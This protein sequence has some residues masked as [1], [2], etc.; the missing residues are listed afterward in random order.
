[1]AIQL[2]RASGRASELF[3]AYF[4]RFPKA[5][6]RALNRAGV[7]TRAVMAS[8]VAADT[9]LRVGTVKDEIRID[10][11]TET[12][13]IV[14]LEIR[15]R[16]I[17]L[18]EF[19]AT[20]PTPSRGRGRGVTAK[21]PGGAGRYPH[22]FIAT[23]RSGH[24]GVYQRTPDARRHGPAPNRSQLPI[25]EL[26]GPSLPHVFAKHATE[27]LTRGQESLLKNLQ[28]ELQFALSK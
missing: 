27:G 26:R 25:Y 18:I 16:R 19:K 10:K 1:M 6:V 13:P 15:G 5:I 2:D 7:S 3:D 8:R 28:S 23:M 9:N 24:T 22:A 21:L 20:G 4:D 14:R 12:K 11:A 17:P